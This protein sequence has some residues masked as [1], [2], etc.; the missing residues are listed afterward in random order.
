MDK[1]TVTATEQEQVEIS[2]SEAGQLINAQ[3]TAAE[4]AMES[5]RVAKKVATDAAKGAI[6]SDS[7]AQGEVT[8]AAEN[9]AKVANKIGALFTSNAASRTVLGKVAI[10]EIAKQ[11]RKLV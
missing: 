5:A 8:A 4:S 1:I 2:R 6:K 11:A 10:G 7:E 9:L 3:V